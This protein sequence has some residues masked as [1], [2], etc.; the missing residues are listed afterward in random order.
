M[1]KAH[2]CPR[3]MEGGEVS[4]KMLTIVRGCGFT[5]PLVQLKPDTPPTASIVVVEH[6]NQ[7]APD[8]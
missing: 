7:E 6:L 1:A 5:Q 4:E 8:A 3:R 2:F